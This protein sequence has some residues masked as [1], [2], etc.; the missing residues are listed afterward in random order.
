MTLLK[1]GPSLGLSERGNKLV[2][3]TLI[4]VLILAVVVL[5]AWTAR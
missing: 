2:M 4:A 3:R 1:Q 5:L